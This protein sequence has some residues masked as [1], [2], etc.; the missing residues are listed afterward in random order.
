MNL[1]LAGQARHRARPGSALPAGAQDVLAVVADPLRPVHLVVTSG[2]AGRRSFVS[3]QPW[4][5]RTGTGNHYTALPAAVCDALLDAGLI[6]VGPAVQD[7]RREV[8]VVGI[9]EAGRRTRRPA[10]YAA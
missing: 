7:P 3:W 6:T 8:R 4:D 10:A 9:T 1:L 5:A 2:R